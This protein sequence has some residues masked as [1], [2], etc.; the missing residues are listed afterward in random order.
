MTSPQQHRLVVVLN[1]SGV[2]ACVRAC[3]RRRACVRAF[4]RACVRACV[5]AQQPLLFNTTTE[6]HCCAEAH[7][8]E[9]QEKPQQV[10]TAGRDEDDK[11]N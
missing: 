6:R 3:V 8:E 9:K 7:V 11:V 10:A 2:R 5:R 1:R 4:V